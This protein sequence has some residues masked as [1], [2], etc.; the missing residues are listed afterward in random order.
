MK[1]PCLL[2][3]GAALLVAPLPAQEARDLLVTA[4]RI[5]IAPDVVLAPGRLLVR[6][7]RIAFVGTDIPE[8]AIAAARRLELHGTVVPAFVSAHAQLGRAAELSE[9]ATPFTPEISTADAFDPFAP[10]LAAVARSGVLVVGFAPSATGTFAGQA[11]AIRTGARGELLQRDAY[12]KIALVDAALP[13]DRGPTSLMGA[14]E[15]VRSSFR[16]PPPGPAAAVLAAMRTGGL[17]VLFEADRATEITSALDLAEDLQI[18]PILLGAEQAEQHIARLQA[19]RASVVLRPPGLDARAPQLELPAKLHAAGI[20]FSF[21]GE[22][23]DELRL[24]AALAIKHGLPRQTAIACLT[25]VP[26]QQCGVGDA[27]GT[28]QQGRVADFLNFDGDPLDL[29]TRLLGVYRG[30]TRLA[31]ENER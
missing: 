19:L 12:G 17:G 3:C 15:L 25:R 10:E 2:L 18:A 14:V 24:A 20:P 27:F 16:D 1:R 23:G 22:S 28:L 5:V 6:E 11:A 29:G 21:C 7:G 26:A 9:T 13:Q 4:E 30:G 8:G 31:P